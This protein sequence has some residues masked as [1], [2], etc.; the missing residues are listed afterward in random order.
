MNGHLNESFQY[1]RRL[2]FRD[3]FQQSILLSQFEII[4]LITNY[5]LYGRHLL[6]NIK[7]ERRKHLFTLYGT[8]PV[9]RNAQRVKRV[10]KSISHDT[11]EQIICSVH[12]TI[13]QQNIYSL[14]RGSHKNMQLVDFFNHNLFSTKKIMILLLLY[15]G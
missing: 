10:L 13:I 7:E 12:L 15:L 4:F 2:H 3:T 11:S 14:H 1:C 8:K 9:N 6:L 5:Y